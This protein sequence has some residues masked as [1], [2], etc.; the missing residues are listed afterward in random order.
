MEK[1]I[2]FLTVVLASAS[3]SW[4]QQDKHFSMFSESPVYMNPAAAGF[5][6]IQLFSNYRTQWG[7]I[8]DNPYKTTTFGADWRMYESQGF[9]GGGVN[10]LNDVS[11]DGRYKI[12]EI[13]LPLNYALK[14][15][16]TRY[17]AFGLQPAWYQRSLDPD[18]LSWD[19]QWTGTE[20]NTNLSNNETIVNDQLSVSR[21]DVAAGIYFQ[22]VL[23]K[24]NRLSLGLAFHHLGAQK[25]NFLAL[26]DRLYRK[27]LVH[28]QYVHNTSD[29]F[30]VAPAFYLFFQGPN[31]EIT[32]GSNFRYLL[33][34]SATSDDSWEQ[35]GIS[36][37][38]YY[39]TGDALLVNLTFD[40]KDFTVG[41]AYDLN[42]SSLSVASSGSGALEFFLRYRIRYGKK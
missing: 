39:R 25:I 41:A 21:F 7:S 1:R 3:F 2:L 16:K 14:L 20:F 30:S 17:L 27:V 8:S 13:A 34:G 26:E 6:G 37:G 18:K 31:R 35:S 9:F 36:L 15:E 33:K 5:S 32:F 29:D 23:S 10:F 4:A 40:V 38:L 42:T 28:G 11:G 24:R 22:E 12:N 19:N